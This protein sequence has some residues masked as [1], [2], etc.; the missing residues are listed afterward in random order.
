MDKYQ[1]F[2][3]SDA[4]LSNLIQSIEAQVADWSY[5]LS[6]ASVAQ[7]ETLKLRAI[8]ASLALDQ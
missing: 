5:A 6:L 7:L 4:E 8:Q 1:T 3:Q 2:N